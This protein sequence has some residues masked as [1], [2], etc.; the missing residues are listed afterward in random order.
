MFAYGAIY[1]DQ[2][3]RL[4]QGRVAELHREAAAARLARAGKPGKSLAGRLLAAVAS[5]RETMAIV[6][7][8]FNPALPSL[9]GYPSRS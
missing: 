6:A 2:A 3:L 8:D 5:L 9:E 1:A 7:G 4:A